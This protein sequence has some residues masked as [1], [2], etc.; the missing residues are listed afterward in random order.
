VPHFERLFERNG[1]DFHR[2]YDAVKRLAALPKDERHATLRA[3]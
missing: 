2:F 1:R 3:P